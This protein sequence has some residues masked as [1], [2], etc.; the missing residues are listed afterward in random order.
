MQTDL[1]SSSAEKSRSWQ[2]YQPISTYCFIDFYL[3]LFLIRTTLL[4][5]ASAC[6]SCTAAILLANRSKIKSN[7]RLNIQNLIMWI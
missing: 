5:E 3:V 6:S 7:E 4:M 1:Y 2:F